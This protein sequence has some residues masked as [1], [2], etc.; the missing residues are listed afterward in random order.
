MLA[1]L[2]KDFAVALLFLEGG[3]LVVL[4]FAAGE[5]Q[6][7]LGAPVFLKVNLEGYQGK[8]F[9]VELANQLADLAPVQE[10]LA[11]PQGIVGVVGGEGVHRDMHVVHHHLAASV[12]LHIAVPEVGLAGAERLDLR[13]GEDHAGLVGGI[14]MVIVQGLL[15]LGDDLDATDFL[16]CS[17]VLCL[18]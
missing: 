2:S 15:V 13:T 5:A 6:L 14:D 17:H 3:A 4:A 18:L 10:E 16:G 1:H 8:A 11:H 12:D 9:F 7:N